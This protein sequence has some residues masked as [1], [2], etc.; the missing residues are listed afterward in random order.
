MILARV[1]GEPIGAGLV[2][3]QGFRPVGLPSPGGWGL[4]PARSKQ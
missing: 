4:P 2:P 1:D 3:K